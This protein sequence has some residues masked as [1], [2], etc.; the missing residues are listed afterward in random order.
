M[1][2]RRLIK[3]PERYKTVLC[4]TWASNGECPYGRKCQFAHGKEELR[5]RNPEAAAP[6][7]AMAAA[8]PSG[9]GAP[10]TLGAG[11]QLS[12]FSQ[13]AGWPM[14]PLPPGPPP[15]LSNTQNI[16]GVSSFL[17][18]AQ[19]Q[20]QQRPQQMPP[21]MPQMPPLPPGPLPSAHVPARPTT[22]DQAAVSAAFASPVRQPHA[23]MCSS[24][25]PASLSPPMPSVAGGLAA[26]GP[27]DCPG[28]L[29]GAP[30][31]APPTSAMLPAALVNPAAATPPSC[32]P[33]LPQS[34]P[35]PLSGRAAAAPA[36]APATPQTPLSASDELAM[37]AMNLHLK[38]SGLFDEGSSD[39]WSP[40][41][42]PLKLNA[43]TGKVEAVLATSGRPSALTHPGGALSGVE[44][45]SASL[46]DVPD[47]P[48]EP[49]LSKR[50]VSFPTQMVRRAVSFIF[51]EDDASASA[52]R[53]PLVHS[54][55]TAI[56]A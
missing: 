21:Q 37:F 25:S 19:Q 22:Y 5:V 41:R 26:A 18:G 23:S 44:V 30:S 12:Q 47:S 48:L 2:S 11:P 7:P 29:V 8:R 32:E 10:Y 56:A 39:I 35:R 31:M 14:P 4:A 45:P 49:G 9:V 27:L 13:S 43:H 55:H 6:A 17:S 20:Q 16:G 51:N 1:P 36:P 52:R 53:S 46:Y 24:C 33:P 50:E 54:P 34:Q 42:S 28:A 40:I 38:G 15:P 3:D